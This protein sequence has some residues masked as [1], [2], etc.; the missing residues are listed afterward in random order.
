M[1]LTLLELYIQTMQAVHN[2]EIEGF[3]MFKNFIIVKRVPLFFKLL[4]VKLEKSWESGHN[5]N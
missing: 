5:G 1:I 3:F 4:R 2:Y